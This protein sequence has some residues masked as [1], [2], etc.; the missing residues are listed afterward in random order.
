MADLTSAG[1]R[2]TSSPAQSAASEVALV[3]AAALTT[4]A[5]LLPGRP[6]RLLGQTTDILV[7]MVAHLPYLA[8]LAVA[9]LI[10]RELPATGAGGSPLPVL[11]V[12]LVVLSGLAILRAAVAQR[13]AEAEAEVRAAQ[14]E[15][16]RQGRKLEV[17]GELAAA[18]SHDFANLLT[19]M[20]G[21]AA[22]LRERMPDAPE[23]EEIRQLVQRGSEL[24]RGLTKFARRT[25]PQGAADLLTVTEAVA[26]LLRRL[27]PAGVLAHRGRGARR[28]AGGG[29]P[30][31]G[32]GGAGQPAGQRPGRHAARRGG[33]GS[34]WTPRS[35]PSRAG[36]ASRAAA[37]G[38]GSPCATPGSGW[39][40]PRWPAA[41]SPSSPPSR[42]SAA[43]GWG[44]PP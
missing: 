33:G 23:V 27:L 4:T 6:R 43:P 28:G 3:A 22:D 29:R 39:T 5:A 9:A 7:R 41:S 10:L 8:V 20:S 25:E 44:W 13:D 12:A 15:R 11:A 2:L 19:A 17:M 32:R 36:P 31:P 40:P 14:D 24:C 1:A 16:L 18:V 42:S 30:G 35:S 38:P 26:P 34:R 37:A 21:S